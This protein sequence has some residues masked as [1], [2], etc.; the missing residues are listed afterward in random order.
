[1]D[2]TVVVLVSGETLA[3][4]KQSDI[5]SQKANAQA[6]ADALVPVIRSNARMA[7]LHGNKPQVGFVLL[8]SEVA[9]HA[10]HPIPLDVCGAD[11]QGATGYMLSQSLINVIREKQL[12]RQVMCI[13]TQT[14][15]ETNKQEQTTLT[16]IGP[17]FDR[18]KA[19]Q[20][21]QT[22]N[23]QIVEEPGKGYRRGV[24]SLRPQRILE[25]NGIRKLVNDGDIVI[26]AGGG[27]IPVVQNADNQFEGTEVVI[28]TEMAACMVAQQINAN[29]LVMV[30][31]REDKYIL[32]GLMREK[33]NTMT[34]SQLDALLSDGA[35]SSN[36]V[37]RSLRAA[38][39]FLH[40]GGEQVQ[41]ASLENLSRLIAGE[42]GLWIGR[43][44]PDTHV[45]AQP[46]V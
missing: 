34:L 8:R 15:V 25:I 45:F 5:V 39:E 41:I 1:M 12:H 32:S 30:V 16:A 17:W 29:I 9:S 33:I 24:P 22:R 26:A 27:G 43:Q 35:I 20:Y 44:Q 3:G 37:L 13:F 10:L 11:T 21:S 4:W 23:W 6:L 2:K 7:L 38:S 36:T 46:T 28:E 18:E 42:R 40:S 31:D 19:D 14:L